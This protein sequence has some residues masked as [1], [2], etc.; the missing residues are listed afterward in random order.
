MR[1]ADSMCQ[2]TEEI[3]EQGHFYIFTGKC[4]DTGKTHSVRVPG[5]QLFRYRS[6]AKIQE[7]FP[8]MSVQ[9]REFL[10]SGISPHSNFFEE[11]EE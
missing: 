5:R 9:D 1:Y 4:I 6:G 11:T 2:Y 8:D 3:T 7:A 10:M